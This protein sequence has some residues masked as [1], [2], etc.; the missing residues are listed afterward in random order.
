[1]IRN[2]ILTGGIG[3]PF[4]QAA[5]ALEA[6]LASEG[7]ESEISF[8]IEA[9]MR[10][11]ATTRYDIVTVYAL[12]WRMLGS[13][14]YAPHRARWAFS[15]SQEARAA[16]RGH[17]ARGGGL[18]ALHTAVICFDDWDEW[19]DILG[20]RWA[21]GQSSHPPRGGLKTRITG[22]GSLLTKGL[23]GF[24]LAN[25][26]VYGGLEWRGKVQPL[27]TAQADG[28]ATEA[29]VLWTRTHGPAHVAVDL[30]GH[31]SNS[32]EQPVHRTILTRAAQWCAEGSQA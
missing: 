30:L 27:M 17:L 23:G 31:D 7:I 8:D 22:A 1:M 21:W 2:L 4:E 25:D 19:G 10:S 15:P 32:L 29:P 3:H 18:L 20:A 5:P 12:R 16:L 11:L 24:S 6:I 9:G 26:E 13:E 28:H 14:K